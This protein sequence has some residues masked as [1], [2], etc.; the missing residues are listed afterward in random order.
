MRHIMRKNPKEHQSSRGT[1]ASGKDS[2]VF[3]SC[4]GCGIIANIAETHEIDAEGVITPSVD[5]SNCDF[6]DQI[7]LHDYKV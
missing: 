3:L 4:P 1:W 2:E 7:K 5:C 6:H